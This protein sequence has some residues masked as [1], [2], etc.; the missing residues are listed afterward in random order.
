MR[1]FI[2]NGSPKPGKNNTE[3]LLKNFARGFAETP[4]NEAEMFRMNH[5]EAY[6]EAAQRFEGAEAVLIA[7][8]LYSYAMPAGVKMFFEE[9]EP[10]LG[11]CRGKKVGFL[12]QYGFAE[13][14]HAR[15][16]E[17]YLGHLATI[18]DCQYLGTIIKGG[19]DSLS[20]N[21]KANRKIQQGAYEIGKTFGATG[22]FDQKQL[23]TYAAP[24]VQKKQNRLLLGIVLKILN[25]IYWEASMKKNGVTREESFARPYGD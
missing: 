17:A 25:K 2:I 6:R 13:A 9:L 16:L 4:G 11:K 22:G 1:L 20:K 7:F 5:E 8:P 23:D 18:L 19:C 14:I 12:V 24:E 3:V 10:L 21:E 15:P